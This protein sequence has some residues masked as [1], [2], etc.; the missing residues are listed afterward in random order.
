MK[1]PILKMTVLKK[2][3]IF[4]SISFLLVA[5]D[6]PVEPLA[7][8][9]PALVMVVGATAAENGMVLVGE[10]RPRYESSQGFR[11]NGK[12]T[13]RKVDI[14]ARVKKGQLIAQLDAADA[15]LSAAAARADV[16]AAEASHA[17]AVAEV[18][19]QRLLFSKK[20]ISA[21][22][23]DIREAEL[24]TSSARLAQVRAQANVS[25]NQT[26]YANLTADRDG[27]VTT[28]RAEPGQVVQAG[29]AIVQIADTNE[30]EVLVAVP[31]SR[32][33]EVKIGTLVTVKMWANREKSY[34][35]VVREI[36]PEADSSTR[37][38]NLRVSINDA[39][40]AVK[41]G[42]TAGVKFNQKG[43][44]NDAQPDLALLIPSSALTEI[45]GKKIVWVIDADNKA[46]PREVV[47]GQF[48][49]EGVLI[50]SGLQAGEKIAIAGVH[51]LIKNQLVKPMVDKTVEP[52]A[53]AEVNV[54]P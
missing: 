51:T 23:L 46:Q 18:E 43:T 29:E 45:N 28:I 41:L 8:P 36:A 49:E 4:S 33:T 17:L 48:S 5:C 25:G 35:G 22:A 40:D 54:T 10:V 47:A 50:T 31:E 37:A 27:V 6:K 20:F 13:A 15:N 1:T 30:I 24:K 42:M 12:I 7:P 53:K 2:L 38:F 39:D 19:R 9:R 3:I 21:S 52:I 32:M 14:G 26:Q 16:R 11:I 34:S 44:Q